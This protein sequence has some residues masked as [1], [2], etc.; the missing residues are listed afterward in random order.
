MDVADFNRNVAPDFQKSWSTTLCYISY[1]RGEIKHSDGGSKMKPSR[2]FVV[3]ANNYGSMIGIFISESFIMR[4]HTHTCTHKHTCAYT[5]IQFPYCKDRSF[6]YASFFS[7]SR[8]NRLSC[9]RFFPFWGKVIHG[10]NKTIIASS[11]ELF[12]LCSRPW[13]LS[14]LKLKF[15]CLS[16]WV[17]MMMNLWSTEG[18]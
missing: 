13:L 9:Y 16:I 2:P 10:S 8:L 1:D 3:L 15:Y 14:K 5:Q 18:I 6:N 4:K 17:I 12:T 11:E 7:F